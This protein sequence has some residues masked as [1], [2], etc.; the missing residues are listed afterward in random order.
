MRSASS[1]STTKPR[2]RNAAGPVRVET[3][4]IPT[5]L[6]VGAED[7]VARGGDRREEGRRGDVAVN[8]AGRNVGEAAEH[9][10]GVRRLR[11]AGVADDRTT[12]SDLEAARSAA[13]GAGH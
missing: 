5:L 7:L 4:R 10:A 8:A 1:H 9:A 12:R 2:G 11:D 13:R 6:P 3:I